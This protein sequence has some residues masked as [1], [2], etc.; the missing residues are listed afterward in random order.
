[1]TGDRFIL[2]TE[3]QGGYF[4]AIR[5]GT[6]EQYDDAVKTGVLH[7]PVEGETRD[8]HPL[9]F[10]AIGTIDANHDF[11]LDRS[12]DPISEEAAV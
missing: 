11:V 7:I 2:W 3:Y 12:R 9:K 8:S 5:H 4:H 6:Q 10:I 1:M